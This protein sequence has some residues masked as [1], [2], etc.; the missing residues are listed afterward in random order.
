MTRKIGNQA[1]CSRCGQDI[2][3]HGRAYGWRDRG[4]NR[5]CPPYFRSGE[6]INPKRKRHTIASGLMEFRRHP[7]GG[8]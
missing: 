1:A 6:L 3:W 8:G 7:I 4:N 5:E 2:E